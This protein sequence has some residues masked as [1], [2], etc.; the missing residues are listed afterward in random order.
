MYTIY[1]ILCMTVLSACIVYQV[2]VSSNAGFLDHILIN[3]VNRSSLYR[4]SPCYSDRPRIIR[5]YFKVKIG[6][7]IR[8]T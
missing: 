6:W 3:L 4:L 1:A 2:K 5:I 8:N 7:W